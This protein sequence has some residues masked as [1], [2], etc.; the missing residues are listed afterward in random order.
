MRHSREPDRLGGGGP[1]PDRATGPWP[2]RAVAS[3]T[4]SRLTVSS[5]GLRGSPVPVGDGV[6]GARRPH[7]G[8]AAA[9]L[10][11]ARGGVVVGLVGCPGGAGGGP[12]GDPQP[13]HAYSARGVSRPGAP[14]PPSASA[15]ARPGPRGAAPAGRRGAAAHPG[16]GGSSPTRPT[17]AAPARPAPPGR[18]G[19]GAGAG[20][21]R[22]RR[23]PVTGTG[24]GTRPPPLRPNRAEGAPVGAAA[25]A[26]RGPRPR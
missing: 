23:R 13:R 25:A 11:A 17:G 1:Q 12:S 15:V 18:G 22:R 19:G 24:H 16:G 8:P 26:G 14:A 21:S 20:R 9:F 7:R 5:L 2:Y 10:Q 4:I 6:G 3:R